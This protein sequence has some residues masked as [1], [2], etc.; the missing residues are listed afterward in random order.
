MKKEEPEAR[1]RSENGRKKANTKEKKDI[2]RRMEREWLGCEGI[3]A[4][5]EGRKTE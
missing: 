4:K 3:N 1:K 5:T 2:R